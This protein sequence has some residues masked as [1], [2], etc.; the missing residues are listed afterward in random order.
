MSKA[1]SPSSKLTRR[2]AI[3]AIAAFSAPA[4][5]AALLAPDPAFAAIA[6]H[7]A[8]YARLDQSCTHLSRMECAIPKARR[9][10]WWDEDR[11]KGIGADD[12]PRWTAAL[13]A[14][15]AAFDD[16]AQAAWALAHHRPASLAGAAALLSYAAE[17]VA[18]GS[19]WPSEA[20]VE[21]GDEWDIVFHRNLA[22]AL[23]AMM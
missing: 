7:K 2:T 10:E 8:A 19:E 16:E 11:E 13:A 22:A 4:S 18:S 6:A 23:A 17:F 12:D 1:A 15:R 14:Q 5:A 20:E 9:Q 21:D 3:A